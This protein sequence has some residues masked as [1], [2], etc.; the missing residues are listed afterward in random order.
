MTVTDDA[1][2]EGKYDTCQQ[3]LVFLYKDKAIDS[4][5]RFSYPAPRDEDV[6]TRQQPI[7][8]LAEDVKDLLQSVGALTNDDDK[9]EYNGGGLH[10]RL[11]EKSARSTELTGV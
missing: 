6:N 1:V 3:R 10:S 7:S 5:R 4:M 11:P 8:D 2:D 9:V